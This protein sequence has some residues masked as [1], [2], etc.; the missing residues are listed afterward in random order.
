[1]NLAIALKKLN[2]SKEIGLL[3]ADIFGPCIA[4]MMNAKEKP[5][6]DGK[7]RMIP[8][9]NWGVKCLSMAQF[10]ENDRAVIWRGLMVMQALETLLRKV[11]WGSLDYLVI[12]TPPGTGDTHLSLIQNVPISGKIISFSMGNY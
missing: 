8:I 5:F 11:D 4:L 6:T 9:R 12:D 3:D 1:M 7:G 2:G 10:V